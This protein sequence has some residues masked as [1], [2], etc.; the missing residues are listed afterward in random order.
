MN[1]REFVATGIAGGVSMGALPRAV[2]AVSHATPQSHRD[3]FPRARRE[4]YVNGAAGSPLGTFAERGIERYMDLI[5]LGP[6]RLNASGVVVSV[7]GDKWN[8][9]R[10]SP[11]IYNTSDDMNRLAE[12]LNA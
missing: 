5:R 8:Q 4:V 12:V 11:G 7:D 1:R 10:I 6:G 9:A 3:L 2:N